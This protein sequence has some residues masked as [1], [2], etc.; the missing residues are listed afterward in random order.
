MTYVLASLRIAF[1]SRALI[2]LILCSFLKW[3]IPW[4]LVT[5]DPSLFSILP[6]N[7]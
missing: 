2:I 6:S 5:S 3:I 1:A 7:C 4:F